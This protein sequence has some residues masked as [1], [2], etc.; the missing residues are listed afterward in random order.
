MSYPPFRAVSVH[1]TFVARLFRKALAC[2]LPEMRRFSK[3]RCSRPTTDVA[4]PRLNFSIYGELVSARDAR[5]LFR[6]F[7]FLSLLRPSVT[8]STT[9]SPSHPY[10]TVLGCPQEE[11][12]TNNHESAPQTSDLSPATSI[13]LNHHRRRCNVCRHP[14]RHSIEEDFLQWRSPQKTVIQYKI[15][16]RASIYRHA[17]ALDLFALR[18]RRARERSRHR[19]R[20]RRSGALHA[21]RFCGKPLRSKPSRVTPRPIEPLEALSP[22]ITTQTKLIS[23]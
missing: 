8:M 11:I 6:F 3:T 12:M 10:R 5:H 21:W 13:S 16:D 7:S 19:A 17:R 9:I 2:F 4:S 18:E 20:P 1:G 14:D 22:Q 15:S 23:M